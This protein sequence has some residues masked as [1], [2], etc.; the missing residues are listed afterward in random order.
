MLTAAGL[1]MPVPALPA[2]VRIS[3]MVMGSGIGCPAPTAGSRL[4]PVAE[5]RPGKPLMEA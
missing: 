1:T 3:T 5:V 2:V 4:T